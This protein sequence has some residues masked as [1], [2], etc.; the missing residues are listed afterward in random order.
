MRSYLSGW[1]SIPRKTIRDS[2][3]AKIERAL[4]LQ[5]VAFDNTEEDPAPIK[6]Y[7]KTRKYLHVPIAWGL[8]RWPLSEIEDKSVRGKKWAVRKRPDPNHPSAPAGQG[9][10]LRKLFCSVKKNRTVLGVAATGNGKTVVALWLAS[11]LGGNSRGVKTLIIVPS[12]NLAHNWRDEIKKHLGLRDDEI[13]WVQGAKCQFKNKKVVIGIVHSLGRR[14]YPKEFYKEFGFVVWDEV[15]TVAART[16]SR[17]L[18]KFPARYLLGLTATPTR[19]DGCARLFLD[20][21]CCDTVESHD[22]P[23]PCKALIYPFRLP[24]GVRL[25]NTNRGAAIALNILTKLR[26]RNELIVKIAMKA[27]KHKRTTLVLSDRI[28][29]L[30]ELRKMLIAQG[31][32]RKE[33]AFYAA[34]KVGP[35][36][37]RVRVTQAELQA[38]K[39]DGSIRFYLATYGVFKQ[40]ENIQ[41]L[42]CGIEASPRG[43]G[44]QP[45]GRIRRRMPGKLKPIWASIQDRGSPLLTRRF[46][47]RL[48][49]FRKAKLEIVYVDR[50][51]RRR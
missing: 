2:E 19:P 35:G 18:G 1:V 40:G 13:G 37:K 6:N 7:R 3:L 46:R 31:V 30:E 45:P 22:H 10:F 29:Q 28:D 21:F 11:M 12:V 4:T 25:P 34:Q 24:R 27:Y 8:R 23:M 50:R 36:G 9:D 33:I 48:A 38:L 26:S 14:K 41:R 16:F 20:Y 44:V 49:G 5:P 15:H 42:D 47:S 17:T 51:S 32:K 43:E 39:S